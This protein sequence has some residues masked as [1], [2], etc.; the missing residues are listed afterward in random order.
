M[1][2]SFTL[3]S[4][5]VLVVGPCGGE[6][7][8]AYL[9]YDE[10]T[11]DTAVVDPSV[12]AQECAEVIASKGLKLKQIWTTHHH[13]DHAFTNEKMSQSYPGLEVVGGDEDEVEACTKWVLHGNE[14]RLGEK[15]KVTAL[16]TKGHT[17][18]HTCYKVV[19]D[20]HSTAAIFTGDS[21][22]VGGC[23]RCMEGTM[24]EM[25]TSL[26]EVIGS[27]PPDTK[28]FVGHEYTVKNY[29]FGVQHDPNN[30]AMRERLE[31]AMS[32]TASGGVTVPTT[33]EEEWKT[34]IFL[35]CKD[36]ALYTSHGCTDP[37]E[38]FKK[39]RTAKDGSM[40]I[41]SEMLRN[42]NGMIPGKY[43]RGRRPDGWPA[44][45]GQCC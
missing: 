40:C 13:W 30:T 7:N 10:V 8:Y 22:F 43:R 20:D 42:M 38:A 11:K 41:T 17:D 12:C 19:A 4:M 45:P 16:N 18:G 36:P 15:L 14:W 6:S 37:V 5:G 29:Q 23:G 27:M 32:V 39:L 35:R 31:W 28:V 9:I 2:K 26:S 25:W 1:D 34:N 3:G 24:E 21:L 44:Q 33:L